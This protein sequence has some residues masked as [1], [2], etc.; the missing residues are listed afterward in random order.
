MNNMK[1]TQSSAL[2]RKARGMSIVAKGEELFK[3]DRNTFIVT[4]QSEKDK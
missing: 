2:A 1:Q 4:S 3:K